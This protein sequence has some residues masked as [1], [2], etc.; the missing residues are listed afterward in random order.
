MFKK[1]GFFGG[2]VAV[3]FISLIAFFAIFL[4]MPDVSMKFF[5]FSNSNEY[6]EPIKEKGQDI[7][8]EII[9]TDGEAIEEI[10][11]F[12]GSVDGK[13][14]AEAIQSAAKKAG[15][16][17]N[18]Y[19]KSESGRKLTDSAKAYIKSGLGS[20][21]DFFQGEGKEFIEGLKN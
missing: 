8:E 18:E 13:E 6:A 15:V 12:L 1:G 21:K 3:F 20:A 16:T 11:E 9:K 7:K 4:F 10:N 14:I 5:Y 2:F 19:L 17:A